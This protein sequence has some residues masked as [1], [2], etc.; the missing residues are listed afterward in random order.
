MLRGEA[1]GA[2]VHRGDAAWVAGGAAAHGGWRGCCTGKKM[3]LRHWKAG[4]DAARGGRRGYCAADAASW[5]ARS[6]RG[7]SEMHADKHLIRRKWSKEHER[8]S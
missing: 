8:G 6:D 1:E 2:A 5:S 3:G 7:A 4:G